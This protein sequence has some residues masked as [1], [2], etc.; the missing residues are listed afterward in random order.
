[1]SEEERT[2]ESPMSSVPVPH[3]T[4]EGDQPAVPSLASPI[5]RSAKT[6][7][8]AEFAAKKLRRYGA[9]D[10]KKRLQDFSRS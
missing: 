4:S 7:A 6:L 8:A 5:K 10:R 3:P 9:A 2:A 1:M